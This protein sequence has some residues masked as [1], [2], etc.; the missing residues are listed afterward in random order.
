[1]RP[2]NTIISIT[3]CLSC[4]QAVAANGDAQTGPIVFATKHLSQGSLIHA[5]DIERKEVSTAK[6]PGKA[7]SSPLLVV[8]KKVKYELFKGQVVFDHNIDHGAKLTDAE[9]VTAKRE[10]EKAKKIW[11]RNG[12][13]DDAKEHLKYDPK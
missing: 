1:M 13:A 9:A 3:L 11:D 8:G 6:I 12:V 4:V 2:F 7:Y 10:L 5:S